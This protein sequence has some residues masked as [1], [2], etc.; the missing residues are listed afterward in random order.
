MRKCSIIFLIA[1]W[2][3]SGQAH[4]GEAQADGITPHTMDEI[5]VTATKTEEK[6]KDVPNSLIVVDDMDI[7]ESPAKSLGGLLAEEPG[8]DFRTYGNYGGAA[9]EI[10]I[11][12]M[13]GDATQVLIN[14]INMNS[15]SFGSADVSKIPLN[16]IARIEI[17]K[18][19]G[20]VL[21]GSGAMGGTVTII[22]KRPTRDEISLAAEAGY[23]TDQTYGIS[24][25]HGMFAWGDFGYYLTANRFET[26]G[27][28]ANGGLTQNDASLKLVFD[29]GDALDISLYGAI[30]DRESGQPGVKPPTGTQ[31][32]YVNG[33]KFYNGESASLVNRNEDE[34]AHAVFEIKS[35]P[36]EWLAVDLKADYSDTE[37]FDLYRSAAASWPK[38]AGEG[39]KTWVANETSAVSGFATFLPLP[40]LK[41][42]AGGE[43]RNFDYEKKG[44]GV[45]AVGDE[46]PGD[47]SGETHRI[48]TKGFYS[49]MQYRPL[50]LFKVLI[51][52]RIEDHSTFGQET[53]PRFGLIVNPFSH[54]AIKL[55]HGKHFKAPTPNDL[56]W[57]EDDFA[58]G[59]PD[60]KAETGRHTDLTIEQT[61][62]EDRL[63]LTLGG[64]HWDVEDKIN[65]APNPDYPG[66]Y[67]DKYT[68]SNVDSSKGKGVELGTRIGPFHN[69]TVKLDY[70]Y[71][72][73]KEKKSG[74]EERQ[75]QNTANHRFKGVFSKWFDFGL[76]TTAAI[77][78][79][80][81]RP[82]RYD[83][84]S[85]TDP[86]YTMDA[87]WTADLGL[88]QRFLDNWAVALKG[89]NLFDEEYNVHLGDFVNAE[90][91]EYSK[92]WYPGA[93]RSVFLS[94]SYDY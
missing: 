18:G 86:S 71:T 27:E 40:D 61:F 24:A 35:A 54:T 62:L 39:E 75:A 50:P 15:A 94:V 31:D 93:G 82:A 23:G 70:T 78:Y 88:E 29:R 74:G 87:F 13:E 19:S 30:V 64:F 6:R 48:Y 14:G 45:D 91:G 90:T 58:R 5:V 52:A 41:L 81:D 57:P 25:E 20:S 49:E 65:W 73:A 59:N 80:G 2:L 26:D 92:E 21:Y 83:D 89:T 43:Y 72:D 12:G 33:V 11:R 37:S 17:I 68:P 38:A 67:G 34:D 53:L 85:D 84:A 1:V 69:M 10:H 60:L 22:T 4:A 46:I 76:T 9:G 66:P 47:E 42:I 51:G 56:Y 44:A 36:L 7:A 77:H 55:G 8:V 28:R 63:F 3:A 16:N 79:I 32:H